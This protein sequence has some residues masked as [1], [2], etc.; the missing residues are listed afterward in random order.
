MEENRNAS[1]F[2]TRPQNKTKKKTQGPVT[3]PE[4]QL[5]Q[6]KRRNKNN[7]SVR[8]RRSRK[9]NVTLTYLRHSWESVELSLSIDLTRNHLPY[10]LYCSSHLHDIEP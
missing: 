3:V 2:N 7:F 9:G 1:G 4:A 5:T 8:L 6:H 10:F